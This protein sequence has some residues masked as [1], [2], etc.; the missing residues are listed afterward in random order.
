MSIFRT[1]NR[2]YCNTKQSIHEDQ[3]WA[4][5]PFGKYVPTKYQSIARISTAEKF[6]YS[7][8]FGRLVIIE[9]EEEVWPDQT[10]AA[11]DTI[12]VSGTENFNGEHTISSLDQSE[13]RFILTDN[14]NDPN[15][16]TDT[17]VESTGWIYF[18]PTS[19]GDIF[20]DPLRVIS[21]PGFPKREGE[22]IFTYPTNPDITRNFIYHPAARVDGTMQRTLS[23][24]V[25]IQVPQVDEDIVI[26]EIWLGGEGVLSSFSSMFRTFHQ[27][28]TTLP[29]IGESLGWEPRDTT[30]D[31]YLIKITGVQLG[32]VDF[33]Y[34]EVREHVKRNQSSMLERQLTL[35]FKLTRRTSPPTPQISFEGR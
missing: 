22:G 33:E 34:K 24:N 11:G 31:R 5:D 21:H 14:V 3:G 20:V 13:K 26:T 16:D 17:I 1:L 19:L 10:P 4:Y 7:F 29:T 2:A 12:Y 30:S 18:A 15:T 35:Q 9:L 27:Y 32:G 6:D 28:W 8:N 25:F 23:S